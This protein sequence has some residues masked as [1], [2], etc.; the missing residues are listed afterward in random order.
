MQAYDTKNL[1]VAFDRYKEIVKLA[2]KI[3]DAFINLGNIQEGLMEFDGA[4]ISY[5]SAIKVDESSVK[6]YNAICRLMLMEVSGHGAGR[7][8]VTGPQRMAAFERAKVYCAKAAQIAPEDKTANMNL[9][10]LYKESLEFNLAIHHLQKAKDTDPTDQVVLTNLATT[11]SRNDQVPEAVQI[12]DNLIKLNPTPSSIFSMGTILAPYNRLSKKGL[13]GHSQGLRKAAEAVKL[14]EGTTCPHDLDTRKWRLSWL[15]ADDVEVEIVEMID[16]DSRF[17]LP[18]P[19]TLNNVDLSTTKIGAVPLSFVDK[20]TVALTVRDVYVEGAGATMYT[21]CEVFSNLGLSTELARDYRGEANETIKIDTPVVSLLHSSIGNYYHWT[22]ESATRLVLSLDYY[23]GDN[24]V[25]KDAMLLL[26]SK[27]ESTFPWEFIDTYNI[28][29]ASPPLAYEPGPQRRYKFKT[30]HRIDWVQLDTEDPEQHDLWSEYLPSRIGLEKLKAFARAHQQKR[31]ADRAK[32]SKTKNK[33]TPSIV[34]VARSGVRAINNID[35]L[36]DYLQELFGDHFTVHDATNAYLDGT[37]ITKL[38]GQLDIFEHADVILGGHGAGLTNMIYAPDNVSVVEFPMTPQ[39][40]R[41]FGY[42]AAA[43]Q[44]DYWIVPEVTCFYH[45]KYT[46]T[47]RKAMAVLKV[48]KKI[49]EEKGLEH[50]MSD[51]FDW[52]FRRAE[53]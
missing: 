9:G 34:Y 52:R 35:I 45:L 10:M 23:F 26:P 2:P 39:C 19:R 27:L 40:N 6:A 44:Y 5:E 31:A 36:T 46:M 15:A 28:K 3:P 18:G 37:R 20:Q 24:G 17:S 30:M 48:I 11:M 12:L 8:G 4:R 33:I 38:Q 41:C 53:L 47:K 49:L 25:A 13:K 51:S 14:P 1:A 22:A 29:F 50:L 32:K 7:F 43:F 16:E 21:D 42:I